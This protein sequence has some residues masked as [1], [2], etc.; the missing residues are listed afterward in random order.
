[1]PDTPVQNSLRL[2]HSLL[3]A[4]AVATLL[5]C[6]GVN[7]WQQE[8]SYTIPAKILGQMNYTQK[9]HKTSSGS[10]LAARF[11]AGQGDVAKALNYIDDAIAYHRNTESLTAQA[12]RLSLFSGKFETALNY[13]D[14]LPADYTDPVFD[15]VLLRAVMAL[16]NDNPK[17]ALDYINKVKAD[18]VM[19]LFQP[20]IAAW[21]DFANHK[22]PS[23]ESFQ[24]LLQ[25]S[26]EFKPLLQ[27]QLALLFDASGQLDAAKA[28]YDNL[29]DNGPHSH[30]ISELLA[31]Y[32]R[33]VK[34]TESVTL[35][36]KQHKAQFS[37]PLV[38]SESEKP[39][40][41]T[42]KDGVAE[43]FYGIG[44]ILYSLSASREAEIPLRL[45]LELK[46]TFNAVHFLL[47]NLMEQ[48]QKNELALKNYQ[49]LLND[50]SFGLQ[51]HLRVAYIYDEMENARKAIETLDEAIKQY[52]DIVEPILTKG[53]LYRNHSLFTR[54]AA[55]YDLAISKLTK[56]TRK[57]W[58][59]FYARG[60]SYERAGQWAKAEA[61]FLEALRLEPD[62]PDVLNYLGYSWLIQGKHIAR[63]KEMIETA[64]LAR[65]QD[66]HII[67]SMGWALYHM[68]DYENAL[69]Y[70]EQAAD[71]APRDP[72][73]NE[74]LGDVYWRLGH[75]IQARY[76]WER[77]LLF[78]PQEDGQAEG[79]RQKISSGLPAAK[80]P[81]VAG[82]S[83]ADSTLEALRIESGAG[84]TR[85]A[86]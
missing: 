71:L 56:V 3:G 77:A 12:Y 34:D 27:Y 10:Y 38:L 81:A 31:D 59:I 64:M 39:M 32:Y 33:R 41:S 16:K 51:A 17:A 1:M 40:I 63:A 75:E 53:D 11:A 82:Q 46:P 35:I 20:L 49:D 72:T 37:V 76:Q 52:P 26:G 85:T 60:I 30:R 86:Q 69:D 13:I 24:L 62:Q 61:D 50:P 22:Q 7:V 84:P 36:Q 6:G 45:S 8:R 18:G 2:S 78:E 47:G 9:Q 48:S 15:P 80:E 44:S 25:Q 21:L 42:A 65:P 14:K 74:H 68:G 58:P 29:R 55:T 4:A 57:H 79:L 67:D 83:D 5:I 19:T 73:V 28:L 66:A 43:I 54:A 70:L 23:L